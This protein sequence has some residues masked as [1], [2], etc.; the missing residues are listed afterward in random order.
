MANLAAAITAQES[1]LLRRLFYLYAICRPPSHSYSTRGKRFDLPL[2]L[3]HLPVAA[4]RC[5][6]RAALSTQMRSLF[7]S[8]KPGRKSQHT[9]WLE[10]DLPLSPANR[11]A[12]PRSLNRSASV[13]E[14]A[15]ARSTSTTLPSS[16]SPSNQPG[17]TSFSSLITYPYANNH[18]EHRRSIAF[19]SDFS[20]PPNPTP[21][22]HSPDDVRA[23]PSPT[24]AVP[25]PAVA[26]AALG[27]SRSQT[28]LRR[29]NS[30]GSASGSGFFRIEGASSNHPVPEPSPPQQW[31]P[32]FAQLPTPSEQAELSF[33]IDRS[34]APMS[35]HGAHN[36]P[37]KT[38]SDSGQ[39]PAL[40]RWSQRRLQR[41]NTEH[42]FRE[43]R[44]GGQ[45]VLSPPPT[46]ETSNEQAYQ[47]A[48][49]NTASAA[50][51]FHQYPNASAQPHQSL[52]HQPQPHTAQQGGYQA[53]RTAPANPS[54][55]SNAGLALQS[56]SS[57]T[58]QNDYSHEQQHQQYSPPESGSYQTEPGRPALN[59]SRSFSQQSGDSSSMS[60]NGALPAPKAVR[61][62][63]NRQSVHNGMQSQSREGST[64]NQGG[65]VPAFSASVV[66]PTS[67]GQPY[68]GN[69]GQ[70]QQQQQGDVGRATPQ[71]VQTTSDEMTDDEVAQLVK[72]HKELREKYTKVKKYYFE[73]ED[74]VK[75]LQNSLAHQRLSQSRTSL[76]D[77][78]YTTRFNRLD[79]LIAQLAFSIR[80]SWKSIPPWLV[81]SVNKDAV[82][83]GKQEM[84]AAGRAFISSWLVEEVFDKYF[85]PDLDPR[86]SAEL[87]TVQRN[88]RKYAPF[89]QTAEEEEFLTSKIVNWRLATLEGLQEALR[90][91]S[92]P[93]NRQRLTDM[94]KDN[95]CQALAV[96]LTDPPPSDLE[97]G[98]HM[99]IELVVSIAI[100]LP[101]ESRDVVIDYFPPGYSIMAEQMK[102]ESG[103]PP[104]HISVAEDAAERASMKSATSDVTDMT[105]TN[106]PE[107][108]S[109]KRSMLSALTGTNKSK[110]TAKHA[111][112]GGSSSSLHRPESAHGERDVPPRVR[113]AAGIGIS[114]R[115]R[116]VLVKAPVFST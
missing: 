67:Q 68:K 37:G 1:C 57:T 56:S 84:T 86:L 48:H 110:P 95:L 36:N 28:V 4:V 51:A 73:K 115:G 30:A 17:P 62:G 32:N 111:G 35:A 106:N 114:V 77:S 11:T 39:Q 49:Q 43:Q 9:S 88:I 29:G 22:F 44:Q 99:I 41:L 60:N 14:R 16:T 85:H 103:I 92:C 79:G 64:A 25:A 31:S 72:D 50:A 90:S 89:A 96:H 69:G 97:G 94:L 65:Q 102:L 10:E 91:P 5:R 71:P 2:P 81:N 47:L 7:S 104:L 13:H 23:P 26:A 66:P 54:P 27:L 108:Q 100:H 20:S 107:H 113:M 82:A 112:A 105:E 45:G 53:S 76:D 109:R 15:T 55:A 40:D 58:R 63:N 34:G 18:R 83:T 24:S 61:N 38:S 3:C 33:P 6:C 116:S 70:T 98:V 101:L 74:Q 75:Q 80:K 42:V 19:P 21:T 87:K 8:N 93:E 12:S 59:Q 52:H 46:T 78:E